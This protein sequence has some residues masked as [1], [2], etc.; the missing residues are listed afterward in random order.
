MQLRTID[1]FRAIHCKECG[2]QERTALNQCTCGVIW[3]GCELH[4][5]GPKVHES[6][7]GIKTASIK[8]AQ[9]E[10][11]L[12]SQRKAPHMRQGRN[13][14]EAST[15]KNRKRKAEDQIIRHVAFAA[16]N[17][18]PCER[19]LERLRS[20]VNHRQAEHEATRRK[21]RDD[22]DESQGRKADEK[23]NGGT[24]LSRIELRAH[25]IAGSI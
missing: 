25:H 23:T 11:A 14:D 3:H 20:R 7:K 5:I 22:N 15:K 17:A 18:M 10:I 2:R 21:Q 24:D 1:G 4:R 19:I 16:S 13:K 6:R 9:E 8:Q 12:S